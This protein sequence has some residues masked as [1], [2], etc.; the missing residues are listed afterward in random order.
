MNSDTRSERA[1]ELGL[2]AFV[3]RLPKTELHVHLEGSLDPETLR[4]LARRKGG[5]G[6]EVETWI[7]RRERSGFRYKDF[8]DFLQA[9]KWVALQLESPCDYALAA[10]RLVER[11]AAQGV[12][13]AEFILSAGVI[14]WKKQSLPTIF[15]AAAEAA[16][17]AARQFGM[18]VVWI[19]DAVRQFGPEPAREVVRWAS[20]YRQAGVIGFGIG[21][22]EALGPA[23]LFAEIFREARDRGLRL[24]A[25]A[26]ETSGAESVWEAINL[27]GAERIGHGLSA[28]SDPALV[29]LIRER[30]VGIEACLSSN[31]S[32]GVLASYHAYPL[33]H[34]L[35]AGLR[36]SL[37]SDDPGMF[38][39]SLSRELALAAH[40][41]HLTRGEITQLCVNSIDAAFLTEDEKNL[42]RQRLIRSAREESQPSFDEIDRCP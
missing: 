38:G 37:H 2:E 18:S 24:T 27:L 40:A 32:T 9:F 34:Y 17:T 21:G 25:H 8:R 26:G 35:A 36:V 13:H 23:R 12:W 28:S 42:Q 14:L 30:A 31:V 5:K 10:T 20:R 41:F 29:D 33:R 15:E 22:D 19:F 4:E 3:A 16:R 11:L 1:E 6:V 7:E 39:T